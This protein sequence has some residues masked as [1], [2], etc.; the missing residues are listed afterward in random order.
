MSIHDLGQATPVA[1][2][3]VAGIARDDSVELIGAPGAVLVETVSSPGR[4]V[5]YDPT[6]L[7]QLWQSD[8]EVADVNDDSIVLTKRPGAPGSVHDPVTGKVRFTMPS[9]PIHTYQGSYLAREPKNMLVYRS[10]DGRKFA[11]PVGAAIGGCQPNV[12]ENY[13]ACVGDGQVVII[14]MDTGKTIINRTSDDQNEVRVSHLLIFQNRMYIDT[15]SGSETTH[16]AMMTLPD[17]QEFATSFSTI[18]RLRLKGW[19]MV[20]PKLTCLSSDCGQQLIK[21]VDGNYPGPWS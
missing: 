12:Y 8:L 20:T 18:P 10:S 21:D 9:A 13:Y 16:S 4:T 19:T 17:Q 15:V 11:T 3:E 14:D 2:V 6:T 5:A 1:T 7:R